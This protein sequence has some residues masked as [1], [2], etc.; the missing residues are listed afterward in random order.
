[1]MESRRPFITV[2]P[3]RKRISRRKAKGCPFLSINSMFL[4]YRENQ[5]RSA[6]AEENLMKSGVGHSRELA[7][8][9]GYTG[10]LAVE[11]YDWSLRG[12]GS[13]RAVQT[14]D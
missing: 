4:S 10:A 2:G 1:M 8:G 14:P 12:L 3:V 9:N 11:G 5:R 13:G 7:P 6:R